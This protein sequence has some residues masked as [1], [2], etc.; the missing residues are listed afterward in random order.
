MNLYM[1]WFLIFAAGMLLG[2]FY[3]PL[4]WFTVRRLYESDRPVRLMVMSFLARFTVVMAVFFIVMNGHVERLLIALA[5]FIV[6][7]EIC[8]HFLGGAARPRSLSTVDQGH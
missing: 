6:A 4:L 1:V 2:F 7:R 3:F 5:G 8:K